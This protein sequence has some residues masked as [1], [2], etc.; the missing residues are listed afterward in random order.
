MKPERKYLPMLTGRSSG[1]WLKIDNGDIT[2]VIHFNDIK[3]F[4]DAGE[5]ISIFSLNEQEY[6]T[7]CTMDE[8]WEVMNRSFNQ[9]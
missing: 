1:P 3:Y 6:P 5:G 4:K 8:I 7:T 9:E 2:H